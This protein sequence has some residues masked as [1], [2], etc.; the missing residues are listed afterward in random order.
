MWILSYEC[1]LYTEITSNPNTDS[2]PINSTDTFPWCGPEEDLKL[3]EVETS[4][5]TEF[6]IDDILHTIKTDQYTVCV[7]E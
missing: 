1:T 7:K 5:T 6:T 2:Y 3:I 4:G